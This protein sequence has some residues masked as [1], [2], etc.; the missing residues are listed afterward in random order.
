M[1]KQFE[2][3]MCVRRWG[4]VG[5]EVDLAIYCAAGLTFYSWQ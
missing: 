4:G 3:N 5:G 2:W 1:F